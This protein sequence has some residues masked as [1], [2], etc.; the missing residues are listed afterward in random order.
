MDWKLKFM[1]V[2]DAIDDA[3]AMWWEHSWQE[4]GVT[5]EEHH[6][7]AD[8]FEEYLRTTYPDDPKRHRYGFD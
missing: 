3:S 1:Q 4:H 6:A 5:D 7:I 2:L 8:A